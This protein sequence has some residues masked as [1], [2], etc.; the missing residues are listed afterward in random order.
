M[1]LCA[2]ALLLLVVGCLGQQIP[3]PTRIILLDGWHND[4]KQQ[5]HYRWDGTYQGGFSQLGT[6]LRELGG[7]LRTLKEPI[8]GT[9]L[10][11]ADCLILVDPDTPAET[12]SPRFFDDKEAAAI[13]E[14]VSNGGNLVLLG[15]DKGNAEFEHFN[16]V[17][18]RFGIK[19][20]EG[21]H[22]NQQGLSKLKLKSNGKHPVF[23]GD[24]EF[25]GVDLAPLEVTAAGAEILMSDNGVALMAIIK[26]GKGS[27]F[28]LGDPWLYN[29]Y[30]GSSD[31]RQIGQNL[32]R[33]LLW[34]R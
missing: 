21:K 13:D 27:V 12:E 26:H 31:N 25:Y 16:K 1:R 9:S 32:F 34:K 22:V 33:Y 7:N 28:A 6:L 23:A 30:I 19:F 3:P 15:N 20:V 4:E 29:E 14:W 10:R 5:L 24:L 2:S 17:A 18:T 11:G 8:T